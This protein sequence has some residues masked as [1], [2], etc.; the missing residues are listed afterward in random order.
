[1]TNHKKLRQPYLFSR[2]RKPV[3]AAAVCDDLWLVDN[4]TRYIEHADIEAT[5]PQEALAAIQQSL[6]RRGPLKRNVSWRAESLPAERGIRPGDVLVGECGAWMIWPGD[7]LV[8]VSYAPTRAR[9][10]YRG[11]RAAVSRLSWSPADPV[12]AAGDHAGQVMLHSF[13]AGDLAAHYE[14]H[15]THPVSALGWSPDGRRVASGDSHNEVHVWRAT[16]ET[17]GDASVGPILICRPGWGTVAEHYLTIP[18]L[19]WHPAGELLLVGREDGLLAL[20]DAATGEVRYHRVQHRGRV[21]DVAFSPGG[22][23][24]LSA[25]EEGELALFAGTDVF[26]PAG[27]LFHSGP[28]ISA[29]WSPDG[30]RIASAVRGDRSLYLWQVSGANSPSSR[31]PLARSLVGPLSATALAWSPDGGVIAAACSDGTTQLFDAVRG[32]HTLSLRT[33]EQRARATALAFSPHGEFLATGYD[34]G[35]NSSGAVREWNS[36]AC[37]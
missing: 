34:D 32:Y 37:G 31:L 16:Q 23:Y 5:S 30:T 12:L 3:E 6:G 14:R 25:G 20:C 36:A 28:V 1:M 4:G 22:G 21:N 10:T 35:G 27:V 8:P 2:R 19:A 9:M 18:C 33:Y 15:G 13:S 11:H 26:A 17:R 24:A 29:A 7:R